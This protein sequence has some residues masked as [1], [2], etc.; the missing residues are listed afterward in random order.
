MNMLYRKGL[1]I[2]IE[3]GEGAGKTEA[4]KQMK[5]YFEGQGHEVLLTR[6]P[7]GIE[8]AEQ[9][10]HL[11]LNENVK[12]MDS[13]TETLLYSA[14]RREHFIHVIMPALQEGKTVISDRFIDSSLV[15]QGIVRGVGFEHVYHINMTAIQNNLPDYTLLLDVDP[16]IALKRID[17]EKREV[18]R[19]DE[20]SLEFHQQVRYGYKFL[21]KT[22]SDRFITIKADQPKEKVFADMVPHLS[23]ML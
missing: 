23:K 15:Y 12:D 14:A 17:K 2:S 8:L 16:R 1:F 11:L 13:T 3:G 21:A 22:F 18:N 9:I 4:G 6:E 19:F 10:R 7:G 20:A 5:A